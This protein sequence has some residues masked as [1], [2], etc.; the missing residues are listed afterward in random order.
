[1][2]RD[3]LLFKGCL[4]SRGNAQKRPRDDA[5]HSPPSLPPGERRLRLF[6]PLPPSFLA[7]SPLVPPSRSS[8]ESK[9]G[10]LVL[11]LLQSRAT[12][13]PLPVET[14][15]LLL[16]ASALFSPFFPRK[17]TSF[18]PLQPPNATCP[19]TKPRSSSRSS[20]SSSDRPPSDSSSTA[21]PP[22]HPDLRRLPPPFRSP[23]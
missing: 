16:G 4:W 14:I 19:T 1:M 12:L 10:A 7:P 3:I 2:D 9:T 17:L 21:P 11:H 23:R 13:L 15:P 20:P 6:P 18:L 5:R 22:Y 8:G